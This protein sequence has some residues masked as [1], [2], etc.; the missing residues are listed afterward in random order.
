MSEESSFQ[1]T[2]YFEFLYSWHMT[3]MTSRNVCDTTLNW[4]WS[5]VSVV[6]VSLSHTKVSTFI[7]W[8]VK[9]RRY[10]PDDCE[11][12]STLWNWG[13]W[14]TGISS[15]F[16]EMPDKMY[17]NIHITTNLPSAPHQVCQYKPTGPS[18]S[19]WTHSAHLIQLLLQAQV[20]QPWLTHGSQSAPS[21][22]PATSLSVSSVSSGLSLIPFQPSHWL[23]L[24]LA[25]HWNW[26]VWWLVQM[27]DNCPYDVHKTMK[28]E[29]L[30]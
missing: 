4:K 23:Q 7:Y 6:L 30:G 1:F 17:V 28:L 19:F 13:G 5:S 25:P 18:L 27:V 26:M 16:G 11:N 3:C 22:N 2:L 10:L 8:K 9:S 12:K 24:P 20:L 29:I 21:F 14:L 15:L